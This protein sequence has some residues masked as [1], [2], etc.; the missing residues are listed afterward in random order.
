MDP[1]ING[2]APYKQIDCYY[3]TL[4]ADVNGDGVVNNTD[5]DLVSD[6]VNN[7]NSARTKYGYVN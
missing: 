7:I 5:T 3:R 1:I 6:L 2:T 4:A